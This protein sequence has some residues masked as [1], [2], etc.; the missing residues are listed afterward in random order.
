MN[1]PLDPARLAG[2]EALAGDLERLTAYVTASPPATPDG[3]VLLPAEI[4][5]GTQAKRLADGI[6]LHP[7]T[8]DQLRGAARAVGWPRPRSSAPSFRRRQRARVSGRGPT[9]APD[10]RRLSGCSGEF[11]FSQLDT[12]IYRV[13][14]EVEVAG[15]RAGMARP[16]AA[17][18]FGGAVAGAA[19]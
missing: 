4:E 1:R 11:A 8:L 3:Q 13:C 2:S 19:G 17:V 14:G 9:E 10:A 18:G 7:N 5:R 12:S 16:S 6:P 15:W